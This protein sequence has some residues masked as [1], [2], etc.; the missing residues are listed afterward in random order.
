MDLPADFS[1]GVTSARR[2]RW[3]TER[4]RTAEGDEGGALAWRALRLATPG[5]D[6]PAGFPGRATL[7]AAGVLAVEEVV[8]AHPDELR[9]YGLGHR[10]AFSTALW[11]QRY[12][13]TTF[14]T[15]PR[16]GQFYEA[17]DVTLLASG[18]RTTS[19]TSDAY[20]VGDRGTLRL[21]LAITAASGTAP[22]LHVQIETCETS[23][24]TWRVVDAF[25]L[26]S[27]TGTLTRSMSGLD[28]YVRAVCTLSGSSPSFTF[29]LTG[30]AV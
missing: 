21:T 16:Q 28:R 1:P 10:L 19:T 2:W 18:T 22:R 3:L 15:G 9:A 6:L 8:G 27:G 25:P 4:R 12:S 5:T 14:N 13:M 24:G 7:L 23:S 17:D 20:E 11:L 30:E 26:Q 29:S